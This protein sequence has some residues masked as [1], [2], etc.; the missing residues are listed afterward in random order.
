MKAPLQRGFF[1]PIS[2]KYSNLNKGLALVSG[3][4]EL[5]WLLSSIKTMRKEE[6]FEK[7]KEELVEMTHLRAA[8]AVLSW[9][10]EV[11]MP[12]K[13]ID[14]RARTISNMVGLLHQKFTSRDFEKLLLG[15]KKLADGGKLDDEE[16]CIFKEIWREFEREKKLPV[17]FVKE[18]SHACSKSQNVW[19]QAR[20]K[21]DFKIFLPYLK[22]IVELKRKEAELVGYKKNPYD[23]LLD[24]YEPYMTTEEVAQIFEELKKF[25][26]PFIKKIKKSK[27][28]INPEILRG[29]FPIQKQ[30]NF[31]AYVAKEM[32]FDFEAGR[33]DESTHPFTTTFNAQDVRITTR[34]HEDN[35]LYSIMSTVHESGHAI[36]EQG[37]P[38]EK[39]GTPLGEPISFG[40]HESQSRIWENIVGRGKPFWEYFY[41]YLQKKFPKP[42]SKIKLVDFYKTI[43]SVQSSLIRTEADEVTYNLHIIMRFEIEKELLDGSIEA[44]DLPKIWNNK[45]KEYFGIKVPSDALGVLQD[46]HWSGGSIGYFPTYALGNLY[47]AQFWA[48]AKRD[49]P[50]LEEKIAKGQ[51]FHFKEWLK[52]NIHIHGKLYSAEEMAKK[53][54]GEKLNSQYFID[55]IKN[56]YREIYK[57]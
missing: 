46:V 5:K 30:I 51:F 27:V 31:N 17:K 2:L 57:L 42:F 49:M 55:Y 53:V 26:V 15:V 12:K 41:P 56:K 38:V 22:K 28:R 54:T 47:S 24:T 3:E 19:A 9:D 20:Q 43:N 13:G 10:Q 52:K 33:M 45:V 23:A 8:A 39:F 29:K 7:F 16:S 50:D 18:L 11:F 44:E 1:L 25:L 37:I 48:A 4:K 6:L 32:G 35:L 40:I 36:Y 14:L 21:N 34:Y